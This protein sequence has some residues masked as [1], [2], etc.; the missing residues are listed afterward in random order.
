MQLRY[1][2]LPAKFD[3]PDAWLAEADVSFPL[4]GQSYNAGTTSVMPLAE[5]EP[6][7]RNLEVPLSFDGFDHERTVSLLK[8]I[9]AG[10]ELPPITVA[11]VQPADFPPT[12]FHFRVLHGFHRYHLSLAAGFEAIPVEFGT[13]SVAPDI[14]QMELAREMAGDAVGYYHAARK[15]TEGEDG[16]TMIATYR[17]PANFLLAHAC[18]LALKSS[19]LSRGYAIERLSTEIGHDLDTAIDEAYVW[20]VPLEREFVRYCR[21]MAGPHRDYKFRYA[22]RGTAPW[23]EPGQALTMIRPQLAKFGGPWRV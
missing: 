5:I 18:E 12:R 17:K 8:A 14:Q 16:F 13:T 19:L 3:I 10:I 1:P 22:E 15:V 9:E 21:F 11:R 23:I 20:G 2:W 7:F 4:G 6:P